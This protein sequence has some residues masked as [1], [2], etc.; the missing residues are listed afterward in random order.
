MTITSTGTVGVSWNGPTCQQCGARFLG[1]HACSREDIIRR[2]GELSLLLGNL[3][4]TVV[5]RTRNCPCRPENGG[6]GVC[7]CTLGGPSVTC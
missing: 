2:I 1:A 3:G 6:S 7:G 5:D 4:G